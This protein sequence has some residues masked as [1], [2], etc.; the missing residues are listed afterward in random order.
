MRRPPALVLTLILLAFGAT[1]VRPQ[2]DEL[3]RKRSQLEKLRT[4]INKYEERIKERE[5]KE[6]ATLDLLDTYDRQATL[7]RKLIGKLHDEEQSIEKDINETRNTIDELNSQASFLK[8]HYAQYVTAAYKF[9]RTYDLELLLASKSFNQMLVRAEYL[10]RFSEQRKRD[11]DKLDTRKS[12]MEQESE[13]LQSQ[14]MQQRKLIDE[15]AKEESRLAAQAKKRKRMLTDIRKD[16]KNYQREMTRKLSAAK[17]ME[18]LIARLVDQDRA[19]REREAKEKTGKSADHEKMAATGTG[20]ESRRGRLRWPVAGGRIV[21][22]FGAQEHPVLHTVTQNPG[23]DISVPVG[24]SVMSIADGEVS[25]IWWLPSFG[26]LVIV[27]HK[28]GYRSVYAHLSDIT[29][30]EGEPVGE[31]GQVGRSGEALSGARLH[32]EI[33]KDR[34][35]QDPEQWLSPRGVAQH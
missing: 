30:S 23:I 8:R 4:E 9:G 15:K 26:N 18:Q 21:A 17:E 28:N 12:Q 27:N 34:E 33:W 16:K 22:R 14:L 24:T 32:F 19:R 31:G 6:H 29:V 7:L 10:K 1:I 2:Q 5:K 25:A 35:K 13:K 11:L 20:F 3:K